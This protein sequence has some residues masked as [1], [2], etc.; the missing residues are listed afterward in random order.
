M[1]IRTTIA[2]FL[3]IFACSPVLGQQELVQ[4]VEDAIRQDSSDVHDFGHFLK[5]GGVIE[6][7]Q[8][9]D[10]L[11]ADELK[12][13]FV[14]VPKDTTNPGALAETVYRDLNKGPKDLIVVYDGKSVYGKT[15]ALQGDR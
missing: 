6:L 2:G 4:K 5:P 14:T 7:E 9:A 1:R 10:Q 13:E 15:L 11:K 12:T 3:V 8:K